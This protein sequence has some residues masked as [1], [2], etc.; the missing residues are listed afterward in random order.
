M[1]NRTTGNTGRGRGRFYGH[2]GRG[3]GAVPMRSAKEAP[4]AGLVMLKADG[5]NITS[6]NEALANHFE[7]TYGLIGKFVVSGARYERPPPTEA[8]VTALIPGV[9]TREQITPLLN[10]AYLEYIKTRTKDTEKYAEMFGLM[11]QVVS[12]EGMDK[13]KAD[14]GYAAARAADDPLALLRIVRRVHSICIGKMSPQQAIWS[15]QKRYN[16]IRQPPGG[17]MGDYKAA[18]ELALDNLR[19]L[20]VQPLPSDQDQARHFLMNLDAHQ[21]GEFINL[22]LNNEAAGIG[23][24]PATVQVVIERAGGFIRSG[25]GRSAAPPIAYAAKVDTSDTCF[26]CGKSGHWSRECP[27]PKKSGPNRG[28]SGGNQ[29]SKSSDQTNASANAEKTSGESDKSDKSTKKKTG[30]KSGKKQQNSAYTMDVDPYADIFAYACNL[31]KYEDLSTRNPRAVSLDSCANHSFGWNEDMFDD[32]REQRYTMVGATGAG[33]GTRIGR[34]PCFGP[35]V[36]TPKSRKNAIA[37]RDA[38]RYRVKYVQG[39]HYTVT[40]SDDLVLEFRH[41]D[42]DGSYTCIFTDEILDALR[43]HEAGVGIYTLT[44]AENEKQ[45]SKAEVLGARNARQLMRRLYYPTDATLVN[46]LASGRLLNAPVTPHDVL[47]ATQMYGKDVPSLK[48]KTVNHGPVATRDLLVPK[49]MQKEQHVH[50]DVFHWKN[51]W[52]LLFIIK[53]I[54][55]LMVDWIPAS[56][57]STALIGSVNKLLGKVRARGFF[58]EKITADPERALAKL[59][60]LVDADWDTVG[61][62]DHEEHAEREIKFVKE[63]LRCMEHG[64]PFRVANRFARW[65][66]YGCVSAINA[67]RS[68]EGNLSPRESFTGVK[69]DYKRD[70]RVAFGDYAQVSIAESGENGPQT[71]TISAIA[72]CPTGNSKGT[73]FWYDL[74]KETEFQS[75]V[76]TPLP[77][78]DIVLERL[79][80]FADVDI[81]AASVHPKALQT[82]RRKRGVKVTI[83]E[84]E[85]VIADIIQLP[86]PHTP[87]AV[88]DEGVFADSGYENMSAALERSGGDMVADA[89]D[90][91]DDVDVDMETDIA[92]DDNEFGDNTVEELDNPT[93][94]EMSESYGSRIVGGVRKSGRVRKRSAETDVYIYRLSV[95]K[96]VEKYGHVAKDAMR[97]ELE[98]MVSKSV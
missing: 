44:V 30:K 37:L 98:Q 1:S 80:H 88:A 62:R 18:F 61:S 42:I 59:E 90:D 6:W 8:S 56:R 91:I 79:E 39:V 13:V 19:S 4:S 66:V 43:A 96:A 76:W 85:P 78:P 65:S 21:H 77:M 22:V 75:T 82:K 15:A 34:M 49:S 47:R 64:V 97:K 89:G 51:N 48:G 29:A 33:S 26:N 28:G 38:E 10:A 53:P 32:I 58:V 24:F 36:I 23:T 83:D 71:R 25:T 46:M 16:M 14:S 54:G 60:G 94:T 11:Q 81:T 95:K 93:A 7:T 50:A 41:C 40:L 17:T 70:L 63:R 2:G 3:R 68:V 9:T 74:K 73:V 35:V 69:L 86:T 87:V 5:S 92:A 84:S 52:F 12:V 20:N 27:E 45:Y 55:L 31:G 57:D 67:S 72:L